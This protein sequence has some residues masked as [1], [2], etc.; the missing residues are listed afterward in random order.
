MR[1][2]PVKM[3]AVTLFVLAT[4]LLVAGGAAGADGV[5]VALTPSRLQVDPGA[6][7]E[8]DMTVIEAGALFNGF[9]AIIGWDPAA[10]TPISHGEGSLM[11]N[12]C[13]NTFHRFRPGAAADTIADVLLCSGVALTGPGQIYKLQFQASSTPQVTQVR[14]LPGLQFYDAG[15]YVPLAMA[16]DANIGI[17]VPPV[18]VGQQ[19]APRMLQLRVT[20]NPTRGKTVFTIEAD[21]AGW[22]RLLVMDAKGRIVRRFA[23]SVSTAGVRRVEWDGLDTAGKRAP[24]GVYLVT[25]EVAGRSVS[26]RV[27]LVR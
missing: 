12:A 23:D 2:T 9:D 18:G 1:R 13:G 3:A 22:Q 26:S 4:G 16:V 14:L 7:F 20:P 15:L 19:P 11:T 10:L 5:T 25:L 27:A 8:V 6:V 17:G 21:R 24:A